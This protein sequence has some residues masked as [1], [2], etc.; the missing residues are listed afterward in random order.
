MPVMRLPGGGSAIVCT[1]GPKT[2]PKP[3]VRCGAVSTR[4]CDAQLAPDLAG[5]ARSCDAPICAR[6]TTSPRPGVDYCPDHKGNK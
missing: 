1:R 4:L 6:C 5:K 2:K 3:C